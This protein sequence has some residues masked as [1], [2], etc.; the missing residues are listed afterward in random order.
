MPAIVLI[1]LKNVLL[2]KLGKPF[3]RLC[4]K[5]VTKEIEMPAQN[6]EIVFVI[7]TSGS[8]KPYI[9]GLNR[10]LRSLIEPLQNSGMHVRFGMVAH[11][12]TD[13]YL[14]HFLKPVSEKTLSDLYNGQPDVRDFFTD[15]AAA[16]LNILDNLET[17]GE[18]CT[19][20]A[21]D[22]A[23][24]FPF[25][26]VQTT[27][28]VV[29]FISDER[30]EG[31]CLPD[32][33]ERIVPRMVDKATARKILLYGFIPESPASLELSMTERSEMEFWNSDDFESID[34]ETLLSGM[35][36]SISI[37]TLSASSEPAYAKALFG[38]DKPGFLTD[39]INDL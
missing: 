16:F 30:M 39:S 9:D 29:A 31:G 37:S 5:T 32:G 36:R 33:W 21:L 4:H 6:V 2:N 24:D 28:R 17:G 20:V 1:K 25:G 8:M 22:L 26:P 23:M 15:D 12:I 19:P 38:E 10:N 11:A 35:G 3:F 34:F 7:D 27:R 14:F 18:E 13:R